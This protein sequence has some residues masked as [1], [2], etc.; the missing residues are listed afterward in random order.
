VQGLIDT[1]QPK[2]VVT[3]KCDEASKKGWRAKRLISAIAERA[4]HN[5]VLDVS[6]QRP[7]TFP[8]KYEEAEALVSRH[9]DL[10][11]Y[12][13]ERKRRF[14]EFEPRNMIIFEALA[15]A[16]AVIHGPPEK[17]AATMG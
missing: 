5:Y 2:V 15:L 7:R 11:G 3:E 13:P 6:V 9:P 17:L 10:T 14:Y 4:S 8:S 12:L 1:L 16:E